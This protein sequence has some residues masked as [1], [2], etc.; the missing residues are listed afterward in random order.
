MKQHDTTATDH[1]VTRELSAPVRFTATNAG[2][3][4]WSYMRFC[5]GM[6]ILRS[7]NHGGTYPGK[8]AVQP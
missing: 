6:L 7:S 8:P 3:I 4:F 1:L 5:R 2:D